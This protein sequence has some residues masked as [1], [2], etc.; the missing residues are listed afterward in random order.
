MFKNGTGNHLADARLI[1]AAPDLL[2]A[3]ESLLLVTLSRGE[4]LGL[5]DQGPVLGK[6]RTAIAKATGK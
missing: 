4:S 1:A 3:L 6:A 2:E 5:D